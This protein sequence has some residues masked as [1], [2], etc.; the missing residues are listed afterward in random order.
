MTNKK[1]TEDNPDQSE[2]FRQIVRDIE[3]A[4]DLD[5]EAGER[6]LGKVLKPKESTPKPPDKA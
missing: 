5:H 3:A 4:G 6:A 1:L 2:K